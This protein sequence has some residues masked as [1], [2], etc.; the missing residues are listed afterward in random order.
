MSNRKKEDRRLKNS[1]TTP[2]EEQRREEKRRRDDELE[3][4]RRQKKRRSKSKKLHTTHDWTRS[5]RTF[6]LQRTGCVSC[7]ILERLPFHE[8][9]A[10]P[11]SWWKHCIIECIAA[12]SFPLQHGFHCFCHP[13]AFLFQL[14]ASVMPWMESL[15]VHA[16]QN[17][18][19]GCFFSFCSNSLSISCI[20]FT[21]FLSIHFIHFNFFRFS[22]H[23]SFFAAFHF[24]DTEL[25]DFVPLHF[26]LS[27]CSL[28]RLQVG[29]SEQRKSNR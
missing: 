25:Q 3:D 18:V 27:R 15:G 10:F 6:W 14:G 20:C 21:F 7:S 12:L 4:K 23:L 1:T 2:T 5:M 19:K 29:M 24:F 26:F 17:C 22:F 9:K 8:T 16:L 11:M 28:S 13:D